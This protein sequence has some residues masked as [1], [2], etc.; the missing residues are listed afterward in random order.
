MACLARLKEDTRFLESLFPQ[1]HRVFQI[2]SA[3]LD[4]F[5]CRFVGKNSEKTTVVHANVTVRLPNCLLY[6]GL[7]YNAEYRCAV[8]VELASW[9][10]VRVVTMATVGVGVRTGYGT[11]LSV[12]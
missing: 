3:S 5:T 1:E 10:R 8:G 11:V 7:W 12:A 9:A 6:I 2:V 4:E